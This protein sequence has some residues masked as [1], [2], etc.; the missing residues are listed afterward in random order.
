ASQTYSD[1]EGSMEYVGRLPWVSEALLSDVRGDRAAGDYW[2]AR[3]DALAAR[4][5]AAGTQAEPPPSERVLAANAGFRASQREASDRQATLSRLDA[6]IKTYTE[7]LKKNG[8]DADAAY[9]YEYVVRLRDTLSKAKPQAPGK[10][11]DPAK[12]VEKLT[13][14]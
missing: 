4:R 11:E 14:V 3:Y 5:D 9:N 6:A 12:V 10:R 8:T 1:I 7:L 2:L 13:G